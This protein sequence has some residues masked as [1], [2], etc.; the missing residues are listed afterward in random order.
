MSQDNGQGL[1]QRERD[2]LERLLE[3]R[4]DGFRAKVLDL[5]VRNGWDV[6]D[7]SFQI[8][9]ATGQMEVLLEEF[10][11]RFEALFRQLLELQQQRFQG[12]QQHLD[13]QNS[14]IK[15]YL[16]G[17]EATG[18]QLVT[19]VSEQVTELKGFA[20]EQRTQLEA[21]VERVLQL[22]RNER[23]KLRKDLTAELEV[24]SRNHLV[25]V[26]REAT[27]LI[28][29]AG[30][31]LRG[32]YLREL[33]KPM[34]IGALIFTGLGGIVGW[35]SHRSAMGVLDPAGPRQLSLEQWESLEWAVSKE[36][37]LARNLIEWNEQ[38]IE[39]CRAGRGTGNE[40]LELTGYEGRPIKYG[41][42][43]LWV[44]PPGKRKFG[45]KPSQ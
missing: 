30:T 23:E 28:E 25:S 44:V 12:M 8:L 24:A 18:S 20:T 33:V 2:T 4:S 19:G 39:E 40:S 3:V 45:P 14:D 17:V 10:P 42:C 41:I 43:A 5:V 34:V 31:Q 29:F 21:D 6:N 15:R 1:G 37:Q 36:G 13:T 11:E 32:K 35:M 22:A 27:T 38:N 26:S 7:P 16:Q 9:L